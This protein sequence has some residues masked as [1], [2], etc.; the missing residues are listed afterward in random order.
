M[1]SAAE[2]LKEG[3][4]GEEQPDRGGRIKVI[5][6]AISTE[7]RQSRR[8]KEAELKQNVYVVSELNKIEFQTEYAASLKATPSN[9]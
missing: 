5:S 8:K 1:R 3:K 2:S 9:R 7:S 4:D 6:V